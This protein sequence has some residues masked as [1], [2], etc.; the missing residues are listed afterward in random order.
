[1]LLRLLLLLLL[2][3]LVPVPLLLAVAL[4]AT[5]LPMITVSIKSIMSLPMLIQK[6]G[7][8]CC[9]DEEWSSHGSMDVLM[10]AAGS[11]DLRVA[12]LAL[13]LLFGCSDR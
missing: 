6:T 3:L 8:V 4:A 12:L 10:L 9:K 7:H 11:P 5:V 1:M 2:L 13:A